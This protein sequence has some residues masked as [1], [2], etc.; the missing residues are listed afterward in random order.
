MSIYTFP[1]VLCRTIVAKMRLMVLLLVS[2]YSCNAVVIRIKPVRIVS[3]SKNH[4]SISSPSPSK[5]SALTVVTSSSVTSPVT[6]K[7]ILP[8]TE[9]DEST[10]IAAHPTK[11]ATVM[12]TTAALPAATNLP[13]VSSETPATKSQVTT[14]DEIT[15]SAETP[16]PTTV[17]TAPIVPAKNLTDRAGFFRTSL[18]TRLFYW[19]FR[20]KFN[21]ADPLVVWL[22]GQPNASSM[23]GAFD[24]TGPYYIN[25]QTKSIAARQYS[26]S[27]SFNVLYLDPHP[28]C[29]FSHSDDPSEYS[30][31]YERVAKGILKALKQF[32]S[33]YPQL[34][35]NKLY[36]AAQSVGAKYAVVVAHAIL[37][38]V[39]RFR[40]NLK[41]VLLGGAVIDEYQLANYDCRMLAFGLVDL[42][43]MDEMAQPQDYMAALI[44]TEAYSRAA[45]YW[46]QQVFHFF[47]QAGY[48]S[49][50]DVRWV[51]TFW[52][53]FVAD[54]MNQANVRKELKMGTLKFQ[55]A[56]KAYIT[57]ETLRPLQILIRE[58]LTSIKVNLEIVLLP[59]KWSQ[60]ER[61]R[62]R[63]ASVRVKM[64]SFDFLFK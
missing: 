6:M 16:K 30:V 55:P 10:S 18:H 58:L 29:G 49:P 20:S 5:I 43:T 13:E 21:P 31:S 26:W 52:D 23:Y 45:E 53:S 22:Q 4:T 14:V 19:F 32:F 25:P 17:F 28:G 61:C 38:T 8:A 24:E 35:A 3:Y 64:A 47:T 37:Q 12:P 48:Q 33:L 41:G 1:C 11:A 56:A 36:L 51:N 62:K 60:S 57:S 40:L 39:H 50:Y 46:H 2:V 34:M 42:K 27:N 63:N 9:K 15:K 54:Y 44:R 7:E 59:Q